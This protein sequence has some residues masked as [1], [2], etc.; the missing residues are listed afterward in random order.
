MS[1][2]YQ[3]L[4]ISHQRE[5]AHDI[6]VILDS[7]GEIV[8]EPSMIATPDTWR[9][10]SKQT[11]DLLA[12]LISYPSDTP[13]LLKEINQTYP[14]VPV[15][16]FQEDA[17]STIPQELRQRV[18]ATIAAPFK[19][20]ELTYLLNRCKIFQ[21]Q[22]SDDKT[23][24][25]RQT[26]L[27]RSLVGNSD[28]IERVRRMIAQ[29]AESEVNVLLLGPSGSGKEVAA[30][31]IHFHSPR[32]E[33]PFVPVNCGAIPAELLE[34]E[35]F[36][37]EKGAFTG[38]ITARKG[39]FELAQSGTLFLD[40]I[41]DMPLNMQVK[42]L[43]V[44]QERIFE[45]VG[46]NKSIQADVRIV[47]ATH[48]NLEEAITKG[49]FRED[50]FY[51]LNVFPIEMPALKDR[52]EDVPLLINDLL[53]KLTSEQRPTVRMLP[54]VVDLLCRYDWPGNVRELANLMERLSILY[55]FSVVAVEDLPCKF[56][57]N[58]VMTESFEYHF[59]DEREDDP[60][61]TL[62]LQEQ[63]AI[64]LPGD[65]I[66]LRKHLL[67][68]EETLIKQALIRSR[69]ITAHA[70]KYLRLRRT[71]LIEKIRKHGLQGFTNK[72]HSVNIS[73]RGKE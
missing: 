71:T 24:L 44:L 34:S 1:K 7:L 66:D 73:T 26:Q 53:A 38:A 37:H 54:E 22:C 9:D 13:L 36:G 35:L 31:N 41:G 49:T 45:R 19:S 62:L 56:R 60:A 10:V 27:F 57:P 32:R 3:L 12:I 63:G 15:V 65:G 67:D 29:V 59:I 16:L 61:V 51:R 46:G 70:A 68:I 33:G 8:T 64:T 43:R 72:D 23:Q 11:A 55:P 52:R 48:Q 40:E 6:S 14:L 18:H 20:A 42:L 17:S 4:V 28:G 69:G 21:E 2:R 30:R 58:E 25:K 50:L 39:R 5:S 47:A